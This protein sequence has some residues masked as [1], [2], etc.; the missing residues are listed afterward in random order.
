MTY[1]RFK[2]FTTSYYFPKLNTDQQYMYGLYSAYGGKLSKLYWSWFKKYSIVR[3]LTAVNEDKLPFHYQQIKEADGTDCLMSFNMGSPGVEQKISILGYDNQN[4]T[5]FFA[6][7][8]QKPIAKKLTINEIDIY[9]TL[10]ST[11]LT[12]KLLDYKINENYVYL[13]AE[14][15]KGERPKS[16]KVTSEILTLCLKLKNYHLTTKKMMRTVCCLHYHTEI[17]VLGIY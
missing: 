16:K 11:Q 3:A 17:F 10:K 14:Y 8:S 15:I 2:T 4:H 5:P 1:F 12:P 13:K 9:K 6:K 7:F